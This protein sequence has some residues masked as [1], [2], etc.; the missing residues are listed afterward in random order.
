LA[1]SSRILPFSSF[2]FFSFYLIFFWK[3]NKLICAHHVFQIILCMEEN[4]CIN[5]LMDL[6][7]TMPFVLVSF[8]SSFFSFIFML[9]FFSS[10]EN[11]RNWRSNSESRYSLIWFYC[12]QFRELKGTI[13]QWNKWIVG[14]GVGLTFGLVFLILLAILVLLFIKRQKKK[15]MEKF[16]EISMVF[17]FLFLFFFSISFVNQLF[18]SNVIRKKGIFTFLSWVNE[19]DSPPEKVF[20]LAF[21]KK[22]K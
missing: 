6:V 13:N 3:N 4:V 15:Q 16:S 9:I 5:V 2:S 21:F 14:L 22:N 7:Q 1:C 12:Y 10:L 11:H 19:I 17:F 8:S 20:F 18:I